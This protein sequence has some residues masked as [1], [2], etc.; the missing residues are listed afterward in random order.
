MFTLSTVIRVYIMLSIV[1]IVAFFV[2]LTTID[3]VLE[4]V[5][6]K[7]GTDVEAIFKELYISVIILSLSTII[8]GVFVSIFIMDRGVN[9]YK[10]FL[11]RFDSVAQQSTIRPS[12]LKFPSQD[13]FGDLGEQLNNFI[14]K[15]DF[16]DQKKTILAQLEKE[17]FEL[18]AAASYHAILVVNTD[19]H[20]PY[21]SFYNQTFKDSFLKKN[22]FIDN[23]GKTQTQY[24]MIDDTPIVNLLI[25][26]E[27]HSSFL[28]SL[29]I[30]QLKNNMILWEK[31]HSLVNM[32][33]SELSGSKK[34]KFEEVICAP[35]NNKQENIMNQM[36]YIFIGPTLLEKDKKVK[37]ETIE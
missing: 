7:I 26:D 17:K 6:V 19:T 13:E 10:D 20:E 2:M 37:K 25:K 16:Y 33:F 29:Q 11:R 24:F 4:P 8:F 12:M 23:H 14:Q 34:Y 27:E 5:W 28:S 18:V 9:K 30:N 15:I 22:V 35:I 21:V 32:V 1:V 31:S 3:V 36:V